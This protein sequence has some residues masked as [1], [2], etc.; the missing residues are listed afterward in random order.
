MTPFVV[1]PLAFPMLPLISPPPP[2]PN[3]LIGPI[4]VRFLSVALVKISNSSVKLSFVSSFEPLVAVIPSPY[5]CIVVEMNVVDCL[6]WL[7]PLLFSIDEFDREC[8]ATDI[9]E[10]L[11][12]LDDALISDDL[13]TILETDDEL[14][15]ISLS[16]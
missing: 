11:A 14:L 10:V 12:T 3:T 6:L 1:F 13:V 9:D 8:D 5:E 4:V 7:E 15:G 16:R 2:L